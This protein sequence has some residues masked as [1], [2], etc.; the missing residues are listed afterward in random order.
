MHTAQGNFTGPNKVIALFLH[1]YI[2]LGAG[3]EAD[4]GA[5]QLAGPDTVR[6]KH[7]DRFI[8]AQLKL[9]SLAVLL[10]NIRLVTRGTKLFPRIN[11]APSS[12]ST[13]SNAWC[14]SIF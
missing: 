14:V 5:T 7:C 12:G 11:G 10:S 3:L 2:C 4:G 13:S 6:L 1:V 9:Q 8:S